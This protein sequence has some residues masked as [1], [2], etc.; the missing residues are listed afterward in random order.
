MRGPDQAFI[1]F[2]VALKAIERSER[3]IV[4]FYDVERVLWRK[5]KYKQQ[6]IVTAVHEGS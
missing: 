4:C 5:Q 3:R 6:I 2:V 1:A